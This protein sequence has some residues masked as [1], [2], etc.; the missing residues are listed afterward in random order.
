MCIVIIVCSIAPQSHFQSSN[1]IHNP[2][3]IRTIFIPILNP[4]HPFPSLSHH[5]LHG[6]FCTDRQ[7][8]K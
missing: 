7:M 8:V 3:G 2:N 4:S 1:S 5:H 6:A